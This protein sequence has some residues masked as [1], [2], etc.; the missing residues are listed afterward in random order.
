M[1]RGPQT[2]A[3]GRIQK[4]PEAALTVQTGQK[5]L[6]DMLNKMHGEM[7]RALPRHLPPERMMRIVLTALRTTPDLAICTPASFLGCVISAAQLGLEVNTPL[8]QAYLIPRKSK[9]VQPPFK[10]CT[11]IIGYQGMLDMAR[12]SGIVDDVYAYVVREGDKFTYTLGT[13]RKI[14]HELSDDPAREQRKITHVYAVAVLTNGSKPFIVLTAAQIDARRAM[15]AA[16]EYGPWVTHP[17]AMTLKTGVR[18]LNTWLPK[19]AEMARAEALEVA[20]DQGKSVLSAA[21]EI[22]TDILASHGIKD[23]GEA[24]VEEK[25][26][27]AQ[28][29]DGGKAAPPAVETKAEGGAS[30]EATVPT[31][32][33]AEA[34]VAQTAEEAPHL[35]PVTV[36]KPE[37]DDGDVTTL[38]RLS[39]QA[40]GMLKRTFL[41]ESPKGSKGWYLSDPATLRRVNPTADRGVLVLKEGTP[42]MDRE[43]CARYVLAVRETLRDEAGV[44]AA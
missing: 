19:S 36:D 7:A 30:A 31:G 40:Q 13:D 35:E 42:R 18:A 25:Q 32:A 2:D 14:T 9:R 41:V 6:T 3:S 16:S 10:E 43:T 12:R 4:A 23:E 34:A 8:G 1:A 39:T 38:M 22:V 21:D 37:V 20:A 17:E 29:S 24:V 44:E 33:G 28:E 11:L 15:S 5:N 27:A 26:P